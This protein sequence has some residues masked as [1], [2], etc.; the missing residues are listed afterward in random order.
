MERILVI[1]G[2]GLVGSEILRQASAE[3]SIKVIHALLRRPLPASL[4]HTKIQE[5]IVDFSALDS[6]A[7][8]FAVDAVICSLGTTIKAAGSQE[9]FRKVDQ[10]YPLQIAKIARENGAKA[11]YLVS[12]I[13]ADADSKF[14]YN[15]IKGELERGLRVL[16]FET[17]VAVRPSVLL[18]ERTEKRFAEKIGQQLG[19]VFPLRWRSVPASSVARKIVQEVLRGK[20]GARVFENEELFK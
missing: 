1:G 18:G 5:H 6:N 10:T 7:D 11:F 20:S 4:K 12:A 17:F 19:R 14:F 16:G 9:A 8:Y 15:R 3:P 2:T 13:G